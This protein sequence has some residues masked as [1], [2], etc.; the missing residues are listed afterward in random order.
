MFLNADLKKGG[1]NS[2]DKKAD[3]LW[4]F[5]VL[6][7][8][9]KESS[10]KEIIVDNIYRTPIINFLKNDNILIA[11]S[12]VLSSLE[13]NL[14]AAIRFYD[15]K[16]CYSSSPLYYLTK[17]GINR[18]EELQRLMF[19]PNNKY[20]LPEKFIKEV[21]GKITELKTNI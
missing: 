6:Y 14:F 17:K 13:E 19:V 8:I 20:H 9:A 12:N 4:D 21:N 16:K 11:V 5:S 3:N 18:L 10:C 15:K 7:C 1:K 2:R